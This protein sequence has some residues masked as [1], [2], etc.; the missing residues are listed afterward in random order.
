MSRSM[1]DRTQHCVLSGGWGG[2]KG[3]KKNKNKKKEQA[4]K[5][6]L[7]GELEKI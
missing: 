5:L 2:S 1:R 4:T 6:M 7:K 3:Q